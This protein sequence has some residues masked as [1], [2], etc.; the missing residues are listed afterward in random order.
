MADAEDRSFRRVPKLDEDYNTWALLFKAQL[1]TKELSQPLE[2][3]PPP[4]R[5]TAALEQF[6]KK[7]KKALAEIILGVKAQNLPTL[8]EAKTA[9]I[10]HTAAAPRAVW[11]RLCTA[12]Y[13]PPLPRASPP[14]IRNCGA[15]PFSP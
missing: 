7:D 8:A 9:H 6:N 15:I 4:E 2:E 10:Q 3:P 12:V 13:Q 5:E 14:H 1:V 11:R